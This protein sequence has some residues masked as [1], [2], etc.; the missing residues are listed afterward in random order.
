ME[1]IADMPWQG[2]PRRVKVSRKAKSNI[3]G[4]YKNA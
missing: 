4:K 3:K 1:A 2:E